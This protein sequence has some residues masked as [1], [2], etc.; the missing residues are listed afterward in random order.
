MIASA[1]AYTF[2]GACLLCSGGFLW[3]ALTEPSLNGKKVALAGVLT[4]VFLALAWGAAYL[5]GI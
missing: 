5:G 3:T 4:F 2:V 1:I